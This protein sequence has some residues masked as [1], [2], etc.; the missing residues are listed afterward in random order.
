M[1]ERLKQR[2]L[3]GAVLVALVVIF[4]PMLIEEPVE[5]T[6]VSDYKIPAKPAVR[7]PLPEAGSQQDR[8]I[9]QHQVATP[10]VKPDS[11]PAS[12]PTPEPTPE[13]KPAPVKESTPP[14]AEPKHAPRSSPARPSPTAWV[15]QVAS[16]TN[17]NNAKKLVEQLREA[18]LPAQMEKV[19]LNGKQHYRIRVGPEVD[20][21]LAEKMAAKIKKRFKLNPKLM[22]Y[23]VQ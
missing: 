15:I 18:D 9:E 11:K 3:G 2:L 20:H 4:V 8:K 7:R 5:R 22:Q 17:E 16:L 6:S 13:P 19:K 21:R 1:E 14:A 23:P 10:A 12:E